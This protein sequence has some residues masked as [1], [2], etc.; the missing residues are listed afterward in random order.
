MSKDA[1]YNGW[2]NYETW[3]VA[4]W[5]DNEESSQNYWLDRAREAWAERDEPFG[6][7]ATID[8]HP[9]AEDRA[10]TRLTDA[11]REEHNAQADDMVKGAN[12]FSDLLN[13]ALGSVDW[14]EVADHMLSTAR[15][16]HDHSEA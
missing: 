14:R 16:V 7:E 4:L 11:L 15:E 9:K 5:I 3:A 6:W 10:L 1:K 8:Y 2:K 12:V 13:A